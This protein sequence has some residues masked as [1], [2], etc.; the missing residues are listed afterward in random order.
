MCILGDFNIDNHSNNR[1]DHVNAYI[2][3][4]LRHEPFRLITTTTKVTSNSSTVIDCMIINDVICT[5]KLFVIETDLNDDLSINSQFLAP[6]KDFIA[7][8]MHSV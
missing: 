7:M 1:H 3:A 2:N 4:I 5:L 6:S 8:K